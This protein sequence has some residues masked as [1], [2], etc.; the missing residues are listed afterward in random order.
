M[1]TFIDPQGN[2]WQ[3]ALLDGS[4]GNVMLLFSPLRAS[5]IRQYQMP[6]D[7]MAEA[8]GLFAG[9]SDAELL[10]LWERASPWSPGA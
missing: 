2:G 8:E 9:L 4:Y 3:A 5:D 7:T 10:D 1:R 6:A